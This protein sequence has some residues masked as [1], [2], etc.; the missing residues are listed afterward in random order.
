[1]LYNLHLHEV[2]LSNVNWMWNKLN[3]SGV[4]AAEFKDAEQGKKGDW[5]EFLWLVSNALNLANYKF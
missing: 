2:R 4:S 1:M 3:S 5:F